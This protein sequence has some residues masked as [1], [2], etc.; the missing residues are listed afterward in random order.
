[1]N[2]TRKLICT[3][4]AGATLCAAAPVFADSWHGRGYEHR[5]SYRG[6]DHREYRD[7]DRYG[8]RDHGR[9]NVVVVERPYVVQREYVVQQPAYYGA[10]SSGYG[11]AAMLGAA[12]GNIL[13][14]R[15]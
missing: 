15:Q 14:N 6:Y 2:I 1:M 3:L 13:D 11:P 10:Q 5:E 4:A 8:Y 9:R 7:H 12:I